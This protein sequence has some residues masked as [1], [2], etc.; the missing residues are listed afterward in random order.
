MPQ[1]SRKRQI[2]II[3]SC[4]ALYKFIRMHEKR[5]PILPRLANITTISNI[6]LYDVQNKQAM[7]KHRDAIATMIS[8]SRNNNYNIC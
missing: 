4:C 6:G 2:D 1:V 5:I 7:N 3:I 8:I